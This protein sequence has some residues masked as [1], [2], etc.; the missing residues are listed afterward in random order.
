MKCRYCVKWQYATQR[1]KEDPQRRFCASRNSFIN[2]T[3]EIC[4]EFIMSNNFWCDDDQHFVST[5]GCIS[6]TKRGICGCNQSEEVM[7]AQTAQEMAPGYKLMRRAL[8]LKRRK[9]VENSS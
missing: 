4:E 5:I 6:R 9:R 1:V 8:V 7:A 3:D 2:K